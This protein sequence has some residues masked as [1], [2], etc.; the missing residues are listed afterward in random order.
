MRKRL[1]V[2]V[3]QMGL[4]DRQLLQLVEQELIH[5]IAIAV[6]ILSSQANIFIKIICVNMLKARVTIIRFL[7]D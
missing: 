1:R 5:V 7:D 3:R 6:R 4:C 2:P